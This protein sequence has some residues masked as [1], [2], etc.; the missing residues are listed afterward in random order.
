MLNFKFW[1]KKTGNRKPETGEYSWMTEDGRNVSAR[2]TALS[3]KRQIRAMAILKEM[4]ID[5]I[6]NIVGGGISVKSLINALQKYEMLEDLLD[7]ILIRDAGCEKSDLLD[8][9]YPVEKAVF[10]DFLALNPGLLSDF[11][12]LLMSKVLMQTRAP[13]MRPTNRASA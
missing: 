9:T 5:D 6:S 8:M 3:F 4:G 11:G 10:L 7:A 1:K 12:S 13:K 2:M